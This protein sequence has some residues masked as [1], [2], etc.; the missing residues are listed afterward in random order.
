MR[1]FMEKQ[2]SEFWNYCS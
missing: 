1:I 2:K